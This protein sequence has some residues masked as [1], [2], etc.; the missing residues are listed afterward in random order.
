MA[1]KSAS[2]A[3]PS[4]VIRLHETDDEDS[5]IVQQQQQK[6]KKKLQL[7]VFKSD[8]T[9]TWPCLVASKKRG[10][11]YAYCIVCDSDFS[12][13]HGGAN[14]CKRH[15]SGKLHKDHAASASSPKITSM[16]SKVNIASHQSHTRSVTNAETLMCQLMY[17]N[18]LSLS[19]ADKITAKVKRMAK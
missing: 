4:K 5:E 16:F 17:E 6:K 15:V 10:P 18:N 11:E 1:E 2:K 13:G 7:Q 3:V 8:Y 14:D 12:V 9:R 19:S